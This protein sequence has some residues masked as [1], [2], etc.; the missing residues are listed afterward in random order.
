VLFRSRAPGDVC[1]LQFV[2]EE[3]ITD[4]RVGMILLPFEQ[5]GKVAAQQLLAKIADPSLTFAPVA[6][7]PRLVDWSSAA[8]SQM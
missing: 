2:A 4:P 8:P 6:I 3:E 7:M 1:L 5:V